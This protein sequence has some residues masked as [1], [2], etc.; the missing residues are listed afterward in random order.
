MRERDRQTDRQNQHCQLRPVSGPCLCPILCISVPLLLRQNT[1]A[2]SLRPLFL[3]LPSQSCWPILLA[4]PSK[5]TR[6]LTTAY[7]CITLWPH[8]PPSLGWINAVTS[9]LVSSFLTGVPILF[10]LQSKPP[11]A[12]N[13][14][15]KAPCDPSDHPLPPPCSLHSSHTLPLCIP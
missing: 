1:L 15:H 3:F 7:P 10:L 8:P 12:L 13:V 9:S 6:N 11:K 2:S 4:L 14:A 5:Q